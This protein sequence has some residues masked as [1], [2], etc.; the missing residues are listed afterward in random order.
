MPTWSDLAKFQGYRESPSFPVSLDGDGALTTFSWKARTPEGTSVKFFT[1]ASFDGGYSWQGWKEVIQGG[2]IPDIRTNTDVTNLHFK[3]MVHVAS[4][5]EGITP[6]V[7]EVSFSFTPVIEFLND[8][9]LVLK[10]EVWITKNGGGDFTIRNITNS[11]TEFTFK[12]LIDKETVYVNC[13]REY[14]ETDLALVYRYDNFNDNYLELL[15]GVNVLQVIGDG[16][17][18]FRYKFKTL[19]G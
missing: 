11:N 10:P 13:D 3:Y 18:T 4:A 7:E 6:E 9:D 8:G 1:N 5:A 12:G 15:R 2:S 16:K 17:L 19:Q 14:I